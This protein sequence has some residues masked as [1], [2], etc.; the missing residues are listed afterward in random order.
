MT[1]S[2][3]VPVITGDELQRLLHP[4]LGSRADKTPSW[5][6]LAEWLNDIRERIPAHVTRHERNADIIKTAV[7]LVRELRN[8]GQQLAAEADAAAPVGPHGETREMPRSVGYY[9]PLDP[10][11]AA[12]LAKHAEAHRLFRVAGLVVDKILPE[13][14]PQRAPRGGHRF[15]PSWEGPAIEVWAVLNALFVDAH[16]RVSR[17]PESRFVKCMVDLLNRLGFVDLTPDALVQLVKRR[18]GRVKPGQK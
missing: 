9:T 8:L 3:T 5:A 7:Q 2:A 18:L 11:D 17:Q 1:P 10:A 14:D 6:E 13:L 16:R 4:Y 15:G 12:I